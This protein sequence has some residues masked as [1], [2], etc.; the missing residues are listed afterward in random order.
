TL[1]NPLSITRVPHHIRLI[2]KPKTAS[3]AILQENAEPVAHT[4]VPTCRIYRTNYVGGVL[5]RSAVSI[6]RRY[7][8]IPARMNSPLPASHLSQQRQEPA[9]DRPSRPCAGD[10]AQSGADPGRAEASAAALGPRA[11][12]LRRN[13]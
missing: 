7:A 4:K 11:G 8:P 3:W 5:F 2:P 9:H 6:Y 12:S 10:G 13:R 1:Y